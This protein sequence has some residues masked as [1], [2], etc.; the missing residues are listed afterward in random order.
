[1]EEMALKH[2]DK[3]QLGESNFLFLIEEKTGTKRVWEI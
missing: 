1:V 2:G 3:L